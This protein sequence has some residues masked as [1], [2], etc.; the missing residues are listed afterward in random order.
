MRVLCWLGSFWPSVGGITVHAA[1]LLPALQERGHEIIVVAFASKD[2]LN[3][4]YETLHQ[5]IPIYRFP[6]WK[7]HND[8]GETIKIRQQIAQLRRSFGPDLI[9]MNAI[10]VGDFFLFSSSPGPPPPLLI[11]LHGEWPKQSEIVARHTLRCADWVIGV[12]EAILECGR[13]LA[14]EITP[15]SSV[16]HNAISEPLIEPAPLPVRPPRLLCIGRLVPEKGFDLAL[17]ALA[18]IV[19]RFPGLSLVI[20][21]D[22]PERVALQ[23][24]ATNLGIE[25]AVEF[26]GWILPDAVPALI[27]T[28]A[29]VLMPSR[30]EEPFGLVALE[31]ALMARPIIA[32][33]VGGIPEIVVHNQTGLL[34]PPGNSSAL[35]E[36][37]ACLVQDP[38]TAQRMGWAARSRALDNFSFQRHVDAYEAVYRSVMTHRRARTGR[39]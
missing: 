15:R 7:S 36:A 21:G 35:A 29:V 11:A 23:R 20:S 26:T 22:G 13:Q 24:Q 32:A 30:W 14:P 10:G 6:L 28:A 3:V 8:I 31:S 1:R 37:I 38:D 4:P 33:K 25:S 12:S 17:A 34:V 2:S 5:N 16:I 39:I 19:G 18:S 27:N 9:H